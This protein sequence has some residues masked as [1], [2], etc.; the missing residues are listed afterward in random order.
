MYA[1][2]FIHE[3]SNAFCDTRNQT[4]LNEYE[5]GLNACGR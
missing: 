4:V 1:G 3:Q 5:F 2:N